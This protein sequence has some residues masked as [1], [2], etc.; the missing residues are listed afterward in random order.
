[1]SSERV[2]VIIPAYCEAALIA[3]T[4]ASLPQI[5]D[6]IF[7][8]DDASPDETADVARRS[9]DPRVRVI[10]HAQ[11][12]GVGGAIFT[13]YE[14]ALRHGADILVVMAGDNQMDPC[15]LPALLAPLVSKQA[16]YVKGNRLIHHSATAMPILRRAGTRLLALLTSLVAGS[17]VGDS[18]CGYTALSRSA[19]LSLDFADLWP[20]YGYPNELLI[21]LLRAGRR[22]VEVP[23]R[24]VYASEVSGLRLW[25]LFSIA[26][27]IVRRGYLERRRSLSAAPAATN[28]LTG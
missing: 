1:M 27:L 20:R 5:V 12:R 6:D 10:V 15:D 23:V 14:A 13:G 2:A 3:Q 19:A 25:H 18:Q 4:L 26:L 17:R 21:R 16:D 9:G 22:V 7:V 8:V 11:N 24:P 28:H